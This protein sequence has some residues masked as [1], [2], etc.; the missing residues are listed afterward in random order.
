[1]KNTGIASKRLLVKYL[2]IGLSE[3]GGRDTNEPFRNFAR[4]SRKCPE[5]ATQN[6]GMKFTGIPSR[7]AYSE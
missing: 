1:M 2:P 6:R 4:A 3:K 7:A 5:L